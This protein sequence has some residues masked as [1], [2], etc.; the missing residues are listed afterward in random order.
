M[1]SSLLQL[2]PHCS[3]P[4]AAALEH[5][6]APVGKHAEHASALQ[7]SSIQG[8]LTGTPDGPPSSARPTCRV[9][10]S[11]PPNDQQHG[12]KGYVPESMRIESSRFPQE[13]EPAYEC[14]NVTFPP[15]MEDPRGPR[16]S[17]PQH[18]VL[19]KSSCISAP[20]DLDCR[21]LIKHGL[22]SR[23]LAQATHSWL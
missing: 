16:N 6:N 3:H 8:R 15:V 9:G 13:E 4:G 14:V 12:R 22:Y 19:L 23:L 5:R 10:A 17:S 11:G 20:Y 1:L 2:P 21:L 7:A 18:H